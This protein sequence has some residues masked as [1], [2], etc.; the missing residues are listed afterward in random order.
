MVAAAVAVMQRPAPALR[1][2]VLSP[3]G[4]PWRSTAPCT[5]PPCCAACAPASPTAPSSPCPCPTASSSAPAPSSWWPATAT[6]W[7]AIPWRGPSPRGDTARSDADAQRDL[8]RSAKN[9]AE[10]RYVVD[11]IAA[12]LAPYCD[13]L[14][15]PD[16]PSLVAFRS[17]AHLGTRI[18]GRLV[19]PHRRARAPGAA[20]T[21]RR[22]WVA[23]PVP[24]RSPSSRNTRPDDAGL[25][26]GP[27]RV[28]RRRRRR[29]VDDRH[30]QRAAARRGGCR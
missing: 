17:V 20:C 28:G 21:P 9:R 15:V 5:S 25:L 30:P 2:V 14:D 26:G 19:Q 3:P 12:T 18:D 6:G 8:A 29:G 27:R 10:H 24:T 23:R 16:E 4:R 7:P 11:E 1:K 22:R 13:A